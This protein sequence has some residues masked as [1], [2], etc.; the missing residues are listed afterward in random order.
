MERGLYEKDRIIPTPMQQLIQG[1]GSINQLNDLIGDNKNLPV[2]IIT[3]NHFLVEQGLEFLGNKKVVHYLKKGSNVEEQEIQEAKQA[4]QDSGATILV[5]I[6]GGSVID[7]AKAILYEIKSP[8]PKFIV[9]PTTAGSGSEATAFAVVYKNKKK[10]SLVSSSLLPQIVIL[11]AALTYNLPPYLSAV[12]GMDA[13]CQAIESYWNRNATKESMEFSAEAIRIWRANFFRAVIHKEKN[14]RSEMLM[15]A[16]YAGKA[17]N[18]TRTTGPHALSY[19]LTSRFN[20]P[21]GHAVALFLPIFFIYNPPDK[22]LFELL[23]VSDQKE[24]A[25]WV[26]ETMKAVGMSTTLSEL[27]IDKAQILDEL[28]GEVNEERFANNPAP[29]NAGKLKRLIEEQI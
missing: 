7:L 26:R 4:F 18:I 15:A 22:T 27:K 25:S 6:G 17:I 9:A 2:F 20:I 13:L 1:E 14:A 11:D 16:H 24:A 28:L 10:H 8:I 3:G 21:H 29:F 19:Y 23:E 5:A 12:S